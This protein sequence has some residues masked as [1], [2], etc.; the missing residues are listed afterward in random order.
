MSVCPRALIPAFAALSVFAGL[1]GPSHA[2]EPFD[3]DVVIPLTGHAAFL[4]E[5]EKRSLGLVEK[6]VNAEGGVR[7]RPV[8]FVIHDDQTNPQVAVQLTDDIISRHPPL[9]LGSTITAECRAMMP[10]VHNGPVM[11]CFT[12]GIRPKPGSYVFSA[13]V[14]TDGLVETAMRYFHN[15]GWHRIALIV[16]TDAT[17]Q[18]GEQAADRAVKLPG[19][20]DLK[21]VTRVHFNPSAVSV[22]AEIERVK[23]AKPQA[24]L[25][26]ITGTPMATVLKGMIQAGLNVPIV[27]STGNMLYAFMR[28]YASIIPK[29]IFFSSNEGTARGPGLKLN[30]GTVAAKKKYYAAFHKIGVLPDTG[31]ELPWDASMIAIDALR[32]LGTEASAARVKDYISHLKGYTGVSGVYDFQAVPQRGLPYNAPVMVRWNP[33]LPSFEAVSQ[34]GGMPIGQ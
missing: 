23:A 20:E 2:A 6:V 11:Y 4:G 10:L 18:D 26:W 5:S 25:A 8:H 27:P 28:R 22:A 3:I 30:P 21:I 15:R 12:P 24:I 31:T 16:A 17:G 32:H 13:T 9:F 19:L 1:S 34:P 29:Q 7:G 14:P 33:K